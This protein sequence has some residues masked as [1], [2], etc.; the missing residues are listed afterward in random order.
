MET[1]VNVTKYSHVT[2]TL[3][4][5]ACTPVN[6]DVV[7]LAQRIHVKA[8]NRLPLQRKAVLQ[9][10]RYDRKGKVNGLY[11]SDVMFELSTHIL[12]NSFNDNKMHTML[13]LP[14]SSASSSAFSCLWCFF[15]TPQSLSLLQRQLMDNAVTRLNVFVLNFR[16][17]KATFVLTF[18]FLA[19]FWG[20]AAWS[21]LQLDTA[22]ASGLKLN[23]EAQQ[24][25][26]RMLPPDI[27]TVQHQAFIMQGA[28]EFCECQPG[29]K[30]HE[31]EEIC[32]KSWNAVTCT[33]PYAY[34]SPA[35]A[36]IAKHFRCQPKRT[37]RWDEQSGCQPTSQ[38]ASQPVNQA[39]S[40]LVSQIQPE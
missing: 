21:L 24:E 13:L 40:H 14:Q 16:D 35:L 22:L 5:E 7:A 33:I 38:P 25:V 4:N 31:V 12:Y 2:F 9:P 15:A 32:L 11:M 23:S 30:V 26:L 39:A 34:Y 37:M 10:K 3:R 17:V 8:G 28:K 1:N 29:N 18:S 36:K 20:V 27:R 19:A 6:I